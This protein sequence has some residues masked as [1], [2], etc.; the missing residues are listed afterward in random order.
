MTRINVI[1][2]EELTQQHLLGEYK[3]IVRP[4]ALVRKAVAS[5][6]MKNKVIP[7]TYRMNQGHVCFFYDKLGYV[8]DRY[9]Q[10]TA[11]MI[12]RGYKPNPIKD[13]DLL[14]DIPKGFMQQYIPTKEAIEINKERINK[15]LSGDKS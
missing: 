9:H 4:F 10:L 14:V 6:T 2:V 15:R 8:L 12:K 5:N 1:P 3:E 7:K 13:E 11:E